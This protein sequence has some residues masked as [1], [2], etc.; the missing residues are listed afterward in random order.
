MKRKIIQTRKVCINNLTRPRPKQAEFTRTCRVWVGWGFTVWF[1]Y[2]I[3]QNPPDPT[4][5]HP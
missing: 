3:C 4:C 1:R 2:K 5:F